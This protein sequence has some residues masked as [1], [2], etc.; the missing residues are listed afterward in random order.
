MQDAADSS[1]APVVTSYPIWVPKWVKSSVEIFSKIQFWFNSSNR[2]H[3][4]KFSIMKFNASLG[5]DFS[6]W[7]EP[8]LEREQNEVQLKDVKEELPKSG[9]G[10]E[11]GRE[12]R[13]EARRKRYRSNKKYKPEEQPWILE[14]GGEE[15]NKLRGN[16]KVP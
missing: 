10:S 3:N 7:I 16:F 14:Y 11:Y 12:A 15:G 1:T 9:A 8:K 5:I 4:K 13:E 6:N 2:G